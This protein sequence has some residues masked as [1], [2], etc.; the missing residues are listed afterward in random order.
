M[1]TEIVAK[2]GG[3]TDMASLDEADITRASSEDIVDPEFERLKKMDVKDMSESEYEYFKIKARSKVGRV[4]VD[5]KGIF[6]DH[7]LSKDIPLRDGDIINVPRK[8]QVY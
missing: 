5:F 3:L 4:A 2:A 6:I 7:N 1:L 8:R